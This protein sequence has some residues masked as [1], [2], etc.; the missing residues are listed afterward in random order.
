MATAGLMLIRNRSDGHGNRI[1]EPEDLEGFLRVQEIQQR[2][3][4]LLVAEVYAVA[5]SLGEDE[6]AARL[7]D[8]LARWAGVIERLKPSE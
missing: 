4:R 2:R 5:E 3:E 7:R 1:V 6:R 8:A